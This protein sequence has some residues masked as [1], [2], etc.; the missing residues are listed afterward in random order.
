MEICVKDFSRN[1][2]P[3]ILKFSTNVGYDLLYCEK[4]TQHAAAYYSFICPF[5]FLSKQ[6]FC[7]KF[8]SFS[9]SQSSNFVYILQV[10]QYNV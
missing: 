1:T 6:I 8:L 9:E 5:F 10:A 2:V 3:R 7:Y 4:E